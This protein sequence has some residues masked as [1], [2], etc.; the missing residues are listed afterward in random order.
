MTR[1]SW[2]ITLCWIKAPVGIHE[3]ELADTIAK[4]ATSNESLT[5]DYN[6]FPKAY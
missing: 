1:R 3:N 5:E 6:I 2:E 4:K